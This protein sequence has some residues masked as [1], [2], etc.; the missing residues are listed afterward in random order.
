MLRAVEVSARLE[1]SREELYAILA[2]VARYPAWV[3][4]IERSSIVAREGDVA[5]AE[6]HGRRFNDRTFNLELIFSPPDAISF[7]QIDSLDRPEIS[8]RWLL[9]EAEPGEPS[10]VMVRLRMRLEMSLFGLGRRR[11]RSA[12]RAGLDALAARRRHLA[13]AW[14]AAAARRQKVLEVVRHADGLK[15]WVLGESFVIP[16]AGAED[17]R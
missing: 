1:G 2:D 16:R 14:P 10:T 4:G 7:H 3:P 9:E 8:G 6:L 11:A 12:L 5:V 17:R 13:A 15:V